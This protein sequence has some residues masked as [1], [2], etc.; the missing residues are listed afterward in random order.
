MHSNGNAR[1][2]PRIAWAGVPTRREG[3]ATGG[4]T[5]ANVCAVTGSY[6]NVCATRTC[7]GTVLTELDGHASEPG[8]LASIRFGRGENNTS[9]PSARQ[10][11]D[12]G[13]RAPAWDELSYAI[14]VG[15][16]LKMTP[17]GCPARS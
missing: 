12:V 6:S 11:R 5:R 8:Q 7:G 1:T 14:V 4:A 3:Q 9:A 17:A 16:F 10:G 13:S 15:R 2:K